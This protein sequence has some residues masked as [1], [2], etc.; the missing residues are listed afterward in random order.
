VS[1]LVS[2]VFVYTYFLKKAAPG[3]LFGGGGRLSGPLTHLKPV[4]RGKSRGL[5][6]KGVLLLQ[7]NTHAQSAADTPGYNPEYHM[8][9][10]LKEDL[11]A[12]WRKISQ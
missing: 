12:A 8:L 10:P 1:G 9:G 6:S 2:V 4:T 3:V 7:D 5:L 11:K